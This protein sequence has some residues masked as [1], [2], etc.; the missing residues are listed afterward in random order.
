MKSVIFN[1]IWAIPHGCN[2]WKDVFFTFTLPSLSEFSVM[3]ELSQSFPCF[4]GQVDG[5]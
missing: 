5:S 4:K 1:G 2:P 3:L